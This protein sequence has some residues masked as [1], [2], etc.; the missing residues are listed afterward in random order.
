[1]ITSPCSIIDD[2]TSW[3]TLSGIWQHVRGIWME[4]GETMGIRCLV[5]DITSAGIRMDVVVVEM[6]IIQQRTRRATHDI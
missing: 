5:W 6:M 3:H 4:L 1:M 2:A